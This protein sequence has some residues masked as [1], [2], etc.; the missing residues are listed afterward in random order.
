MINQMKFESILQALRQE[1]KRLN[2]HTPEWLTYLNIASVYL[3]ARRVDRP[4][5]VEIGILDGAQ[6]PFYEQLLG[7]TYI[8]IDIDRNAPADI[9]GNSA[10]PET[11]DKLAA[12]LDG[13]QID[14]LFIDGLHTYQG[15]KDDFEMYYP[16]TRHIVALHDILTPKNCPEDTVDV[17]P[18]WEE[19]KATNTTD[20]IIT[21]QHYNPRPANVFNGRPLGIGMLLKG[22]A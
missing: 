4:V 12:I 1:N 19:I 5:V 18:F 7:A 15:V 6:R 22:N 11:R 8:G 14:L 16:M 10:A 20:T 3:A 2:Q 21:V 17:I 9:R 13:R